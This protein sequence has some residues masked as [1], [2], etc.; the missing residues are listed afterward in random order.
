MAA[1][2]RVGTSAFQ[3][4]SL[5]L[6][7]V[8]AKMD[9]LG[10]RKW[11]ESLE[12]NERDEY[13]MVRGFL[14]SRVDAATRERW[15]AEARSLDVEHK[16]TTEL[17][18]HWAE[19]DPAPAVDAALAAEDA[20]AVFDV[21]IGATHGPWNRLVLNTCHSGVSFIKDFDLARLPAIFSS[22]PGT[23]PERM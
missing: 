2:G 1:C 18:T 17:L 16:C 7:I 13:S 19:W 21:I 6:L 14:M 3:A 22:A 8:W 12:S 23:L 11:A 9:F 5:E 15:I 20:D 10:L 4:F